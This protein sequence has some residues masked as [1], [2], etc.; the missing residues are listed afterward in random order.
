MTVY[1]IVKFRI[2]AHSGS[3]H[4]QQKKN[5]SETTAVLLRVAQYADVLKTAQ[6]TGD[7]ISKNGDLWQ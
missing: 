5:S 4:S 7:R 6:S 2:K 3:T 1:N